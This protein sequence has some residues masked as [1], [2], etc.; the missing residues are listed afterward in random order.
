[1]LN[2]VLYVAMV[3]FCAVAWPL[4]AAAQSGDARLELG[5]QLTTAASSQFEGTDVGLG[6]RIA[7]HP[8]GL[9]GIE[10]EMDQY[11]AEF[12]DRAPISRSRTEGLFGLTAGPR[13]DRLR[14]FAKVR[15]G[16]LTFHE[17]AQ[18]VFCILIFPTPLSC[19]LASGRTVFA[20]D[21]GGGVE[22]F[23]TQKTFIR[24]DAGD[25]LV[26]YS[27]PVFDSNY[28]AHPTGFFSHDV[29]LAVGGGLKLW[30]R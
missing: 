24:V 8:V 16:F 7:W 12:P 6:G 20:L 22:V 13:F 27:G 5:V 15:P 30:R 18:P 11:P 19:T 2:R 14:P 26:K 29:R 9:V 28:T 4:I 17:A 25:R 21:I 1:M 10:A 3:A 23:T